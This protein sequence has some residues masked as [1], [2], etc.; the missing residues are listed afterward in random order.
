MDGH[1]THTHGP[2]IQLCRENLIDVCFL[3]SHTSHITQP[4]DVGVFGSYKAAWRRGEADEALHDLDP[5]PERQSAA[6]IR[7]LGRS[8]G[9]FRHASSS[10]NITQSFFHTGIYPFSVDHFVYFCHGVRGV[11]PEARA[12]AEAAIKAENEATTERVENKRRKLN[13]DDLHI[14]S[15]RI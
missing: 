14:V 8:L 11:P 9:A 6:T 10:R 5:I 7:M 1:A 15:S 3:P 4:L 13:T 2:N 12:R